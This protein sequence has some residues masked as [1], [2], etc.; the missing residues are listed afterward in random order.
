MCVGSILGPGEWTGISPI[1]EGIKIN[2]SSY[3]H[4]QN[5]MYCINWHTQININQTQTKKRKL[6]INSLIL[7]TIC[8]AITCLELPAPVNGQIS[9]AVDMF[10]PFDYSTVAI[11]SCD[12]GY[13]LSGGDLTRS[14]EGDDSSTTGS[15]SG[16]QPT[17]EGGRQN[18]YLKQS[19]LCTNVILVLLHEPL[20]MLLGNISV[21]SHC[22]PRSSHPNEW[23]SGV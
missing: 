14:C 2:T 21:H 11:Y 1:C 16:S 23:P 9:Y 19:Y 8:V 17:C 20:A 13:G 3:L 5:I 7:C 12:T 15:W 10:V 18:I 22:L 6:E 4:V